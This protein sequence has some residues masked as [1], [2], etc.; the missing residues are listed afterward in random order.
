VVSFGVLCIKAGGVDKNIRRPSKRPNLN[1]FRGRTAFVISGYHR[2]L[3]VG[4][5]FAGVHG[6]MAPNNQGQG[7]TAQKAN[8]PA[9]GAFSG[10]KAGASQGGAA[11]RLPRGR[12]WYV[13]PNEVN[14]RTYYNLMVKPGVRGTL[15]I[16]K[17]A[18][19]EVHKWLTQLSDPTIMVSYV[20]FVGRSKVDKRT[21]KK[22]TPMVKILIGRSGIA[23]QIPNAVVIGK[24]WDYLLV[25]KEVN[26]KISPYD[27]SDAEDSGVDN[28]NPPEDSSE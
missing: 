10:G 23:V 1:R 21:G 27:F 22:V 6:V 11:A 2:I 25:A 4:L 15:Q 13:A 24:V 28:F 16:L 9:P 5:K 20:A 18:A 7:Q 19:F 3:A 8:A 17:E 14:G 12:D 26:A